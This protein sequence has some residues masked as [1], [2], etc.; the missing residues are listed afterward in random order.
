MKKKTIIIGAVAAVL[1]V[2]AC[3]GAGT[4]SNSSTSA[5]TPSTG[6]SSLKPMPEPPFMLKEKVYPSTLYS[7]S[8]V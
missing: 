2:G 8:T 1:V 7:K 3:A 6:R 4:K 5:T